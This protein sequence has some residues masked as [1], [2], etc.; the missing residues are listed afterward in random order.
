MTPLLDRFI[1]I[2]SAFRPSTARELFALRLSQKLNDRYSEPQLLSAYRRTIRSNGG[3]IKDAGKRFHA[4][5][6]ALNGNGH[7]SRSDSLISIRVERRT[8]A[9]AIFEGEH[10]EFAD[11]RQLSSDREK[12]SASAAGFIGWLLNRFTVESATVEGIV[13]GHAM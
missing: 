2:M 6:K 7:Q 8:I 11:A 9:V 1:P 3:G 4:E 12:A 13:N 10:L 5:L